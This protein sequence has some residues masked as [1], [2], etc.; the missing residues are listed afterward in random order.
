MKNK[1]TDFLYEEESYKI[2]GAV[3]DVWKNLKGIFKEKIVENA[4]RKE[5]EDCGVVVEVQKRISVYYK[6]EKVGT[7]IPDMVV[8]DSILI[9]LKAK[10]FLTNEDEKKFWEYLRGSQYR[11]GFLINFGSKELEIRRRVYDRARGK[12]E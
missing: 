6:G 11:L 7:Y 4:L 10:P 12:Y 5:L 8:N 2:R 9:E 1:V 3:F